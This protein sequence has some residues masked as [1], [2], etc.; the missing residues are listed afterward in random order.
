M[1]LVKNYFIHSFSVFILPARKILCWVVNTMANG[2]LC[3]VSIYI[4]WIFTF[5]WLWSSCKFLLG[6]PPVWVFDCCDV[7]VHYKY[8][9]VWYGIFVFCV[10]WFLCF[11]LRKN[12]WDLIIT[13][14]FC[15]E[16]L[17]L[18]IT[19]FPTIR[20]VYGLLINW[21]VLCMTGWF[22]FYI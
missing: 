22:L 4:Q 21:M 20:V 7:G 18:I 11:G 1:T 16:F 10:T 13:L 3:W 2:V 19:V 5:F 17:L 6:D 9:W 14:G 8:L 12:L 15:K